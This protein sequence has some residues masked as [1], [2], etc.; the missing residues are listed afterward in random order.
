VILQPSAN[1]SLR[2]VNGVKV[3]L[4]YPLPETLKKI[5]RALTAKQQMPCIHAKPRARF[6]MGK[7][8]LQQSGLCVFGKKYSAVPFCPLRKKAPL[9]R[10]VFNRRM[11][12][13]MPDKR[14]KTGNQLFV[15]G[16]K[17]VRHMGGKD[18]AFPVPADILPFTI[19]RGF[20]FAVINKKKQ[21]NSLYCF[22][23][24]QKTQVFAI[25]PRDYP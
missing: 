2:A 25:C 11:N 12:D 3:N 14:R 22:Y 8:S 20:H 4:P 6:Q 15:G 17:R 23:G 10:R 19:Q 13:K 5:R 21:L 7:R 9:Y 1:Y 16:Q 24:F 18:K